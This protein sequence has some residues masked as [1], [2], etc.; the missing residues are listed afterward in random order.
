MILKALFDL[1]QSERLMSDPDFPQKPVAWIIHIGPGGR[2]LGIVGTH[3]IPP[4][5]GKKKAKPILK[6]FRVPYQRGR[7]GTKAPAHFMVDN[8]KYVFGLPTQDKD[9]SKGEGQE[10]SGSFRALIQN[11]AE[12]TQD[13]G[14]CAVF[15]F[16]KNITGGNQEIDLP[17][18]CLSNE[19]FAFLY[20]PDGDIL[21]HERSA[22][23]SYWRDRRHQSTD[24]DPNSRNAKCLVSGEQFHEIGLF[25]LIKKLPGGTSSGCGIVG[26]NRNAFWSY[27]L[28]NNENAPIS[29]YAAESCAT[30]LNRLLDP[31]FP[32]PIHPGEKLP[33]RNYQLSADTVACFWAVRAE[34]QDFCD[35]FAPILEA[36][37]DDVRR[38]YHSIWK[39]EAPP[40]L[41]A[42][43]FYALTLTGTQGRAI[44]RDWFQSSVHEVATQIARYFGELDLVRN[45]PKPKDRDLPP[46]IPMSV[47]LRSLAVRGES[48]AIPPHVAAQM[49]RAAYSG[50]RYPMTA[51]RRA[52]ER[53]RAEIGR[54]EWK[55]KEWRD[56]R[57]AIIKAVLIRNYKKEVKREMDPNSNSQ[58]YNLG[59][60]MAVLERIQL[61]ALGDINANV[62]DRFFS[63][64][65]ATPK[66]IFTRL[67]KNARN[68]V[69]KAKDDP[70]NRGLIFLLDKL[71]DELSLP[72]GPKD[73]GFPSHLALDEQGL[74][75][76][77]YHHMRHW[78]WMGK[79]ERQTWESVH[80]DAPRAYCW[81]KQPAEPANATEL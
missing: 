25:P 55:D 45:T 76:I 26:F 81:S 20:E 31:T 19:Q 41:D 57:A 10:K 70:A 12:K 59:R 67:M 15:E 22:V 34:A 27:G 65:S 75:V 37:P 79:E 68:H 13:E 44:V 73:C 54:K 53:M 6:D 62:I 17:E 28:K 36:N 29:R 32:D 60:L 78:L 21:V 40:D 58:G 48:D 38:S 66:A 18:G 3:T 7:C 23:E 43:A 2:Y 80:P 8:A 39:G 49:A 5:E 35:Q 61:E 56:A 52:L 42:S 30:A 74:F 50:A 4:Q 16:L 11:C 9:F 24:D 14:V 69:R 33:K 47:L 46:Q 51:Y 63:G 72:F 77:G 1:A 64:A 71:L